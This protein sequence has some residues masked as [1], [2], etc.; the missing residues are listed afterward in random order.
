MLCHV[1][2]IR[3]N[4]QI[5]EL[6]KGIIKSI[7][8]THNDL[9]VRYLEYMETSVGR[10]ILENLTETQNVFSSITRHNVIIFNHFT[11]T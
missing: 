7:E 6:T 8:S 11:F 2:F 3:H 1:S 9:R 5:V 10:L 4:Y